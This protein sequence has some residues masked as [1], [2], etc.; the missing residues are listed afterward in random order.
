M[1]VACALVLLTG[2]F[3]G[4]T[5]KPDESKP[6]GK[7]QDGIPLIITDKIPEAPENKTPL[8]SQSQTQSQSQNQTQDNHPAAPRKSSLKEAFE[9]K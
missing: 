8:Q 1:V 5:P 3:S 4:C 9:G 6:T 2:I 7:K